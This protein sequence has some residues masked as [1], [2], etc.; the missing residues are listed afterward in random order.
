MKIAPDSRGRDG[1]GMMA[2]APGLST[3]FAETAMAIPI[4]SF[5]ICHIFL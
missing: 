3:D 5:F 1:A 4:I 2:N